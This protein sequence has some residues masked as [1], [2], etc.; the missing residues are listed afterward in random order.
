M[1]RRSGDKNILVVGPYSSAPAVYGVRVR[2]SRGGQADRLFFLPKV[3]LPYVYTVGTPTDPARP[4]GEI[5][6]AYVQDGDTVEIEANTYWSRLV[7]R[8]DQLAVDQP[9]VT[10]TWQV[11]FGVLNDDIQLTNTSRVP[12]TNV[13]FKPRIEAGGRIWELTLKAG[14]IG[15][16]EVFT[17]DNAVSIPGSH[18]DRASATLVCDQSPASQK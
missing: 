9:D 4:T 3:E 14:R 1:I 5:D 15:P 13:R 6:P 12:L 10:F 16:G 17:W 18:W 8:F 2:I 11:K 7:Y